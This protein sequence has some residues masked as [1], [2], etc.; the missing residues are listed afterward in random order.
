MAFSQAQ[1]DALDTAIARGTRTV[2]YD[3][4]SVTYHSLDEML[5]LRSTMEAS[6][7]AANGTTKTKS[8][9]STFKRG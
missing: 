9:L 6:I 4:T 7:A 5:R 8:S 2:S 1:L 3:G